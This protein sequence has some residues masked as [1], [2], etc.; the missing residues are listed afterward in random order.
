MR[1][2][3]ILA[4]LCLVPA[5]LCAQQWQQASTPAFTLLTDAKE[6]EARELALRLEQW[7]GLFGQILHKNDPRVAV[8]LRIIVARPESYA[9]DRT[10]AELVRSMPA[11]GWQRD[12]DVIVV[13]STSPNEYNGLAALFA[14]RLLEYN[15]PRTQPWF[16]LGIEELFAAV[17]L[18]P[19]DLQ[20]AGPHPN[21]PAQAHWIPVRE[22]FSAAPRAQHT[23]RMTIAELRAAVDVLDPQDFAAESWTVMR[24]LLANQ[25]ISEAGTYFGLIMTQ[26]Q[27]VDEAIQNAFGMSA[28][29]LDAELQ[30]FAH[31][32]PK[33]ISMPLPSNA[34]PESIP[35]KKVMPPTARAM[36]AESAASLLEDPAPAVSALDTMMKQDQENAALHR[37]LAVTYMR[38]HRMDLMIENVRRAIALEDTDPRMHYFYAVFLN[39]GSRD[40]VRVESAVA[41]LSGELTIALRMDP[42]Y[43]EAHD[44]YGLCLAAADKYAQAINELGQA[45]RA[46][47]RNE[48]YM[49]NM[50]HA[51]AASGDERNARNML[52]LLSRSAQPEIARDARQQLTGMSEQHNKVKSWADKY[53]NMQDTV[54]P[55]WRAHD[56]LGVIPDSDEKLARNDAAPD[57]RKVENLKGKIVSVECSAEGSALLHVNANGRPWTFKAPNYANTVLIGPDRFDCGW[58]NVNASIN[59]KPS[60]KQQGDLVTLEID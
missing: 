58:H 12:G 42:S 6:L 46:A 16:D 56:G 8:P 20:L 50:A 49:L 22:L 11:G 40:A 5:A 3:I 21:L 10:T 30:R 24:W 13:D 28:A 54:D 44:L 29:E 32:P 39:D 17:K 26:G 36:L 51:L 35:T 9:H 43:A 38:Q 19:K 47:P 31:Q 15:Y 45:R 23:Y 4:L 2:K 48:R 14:N 57:T 34:L 55:K 53:S 1:S 52:A 59:Y 18:T 60:G 41:R 33:P 25:R 37:A 7:R 27:S